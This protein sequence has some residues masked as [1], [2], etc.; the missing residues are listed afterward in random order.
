MPTSADDIFLRRPATL[1]ELLSSEQKVV[2]AGGTISGISDVREDNG[3][4]SLEGGVTGVGGRVRLASM[5][6]D[7]DDPDDMSV[8]I[9]GDGET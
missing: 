4:A 3:I 9:L 8:K 2:G 5:S 1:I 7:C 6:V